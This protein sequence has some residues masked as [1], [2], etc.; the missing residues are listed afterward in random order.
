MNARGIVWFAL[1]MVFGGLFW[2]VGASRTTAQGRGTDGSGFSSG[3]E[4][5]RQGAGMRVAASAATSDGFT[6]VVGVLSGLRAHLQDADPAQS[7]R[8][9]LSGVQLPEGAYITSSYSA[10]RNGKQVAIIRIDAIDTKNGR[11]TWTH[12]TVIDK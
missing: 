6:E 10:F 8:E 3:A 11:T 5:D 9:V 1:L 7:S 2:L 12:E 4:G